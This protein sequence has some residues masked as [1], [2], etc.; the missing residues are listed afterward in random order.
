[1]A[2]VSRYAPIL[3][4]IAGR[5]AGED[6][7]QLRTDPV[8]WAYALRDA[9]D[10]ARP[11]LVVSHLDDRLEADAVLGA[12]EPD[13]D[14]AGRLLSAPALAG[15][16][17][18]TA[19]AELVRTL[20]AIYLARPPVAAT[21]TAPSTM[22]ARLAPELLP[23]G[24]SEEDRIELAE[25]CGDLLAGLAVAYAEAGAAVLIVIESDPSFLESEADRDGA[26]LP[27]E[28]VAGHQRVELV[29]VGGADGVAPGVWGLP[30]EQFAVEWPRAAAAVPGDLLLSAGAIP[31]DIPLENLR[32]ATE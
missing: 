19:V 1:V 30:P 7:S 21:L 9:V 3:Q 5:I 11:D 6:P 14:W 15:V 12:T 13:E 23:S 24:S 31:G 16:A 25:I 8:G 22:A 10:L 17:P 28:R 20:S 2:L 29:V 4:E 32:L 18:T 27:V 26:L